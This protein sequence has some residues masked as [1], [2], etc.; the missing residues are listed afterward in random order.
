MI[1]VMAKIRI[2]L[3]LAKLRIR[4]EVLVRAADVI[5]LRRI[6]LPLLAARTETPAARFPTTVFCATVVQVALYIRMPSPPFGIR[7]PSVPM[8]TSLPITEL[9]VVLSYATPKIAMPW[10]LTVRLVARSDVAVSVA[11]VRPIA[12][13]LV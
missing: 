13:M 2:K 9:S 3:D 12:S 11:A 8:P 1:G 5:E 6:A 10:L 4:L 7:T